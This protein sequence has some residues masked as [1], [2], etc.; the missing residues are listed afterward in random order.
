V[1]KSKSGA[2]LIKKLG[3][4]IKTRKSKNTDYILVD[5]KKD[6][7]DLEGRYKVI[8]IDDLKKE[9]EKVL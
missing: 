7:K 6:E 9:I 4:N 3:G 8:T 2:E 1:N 5:Y